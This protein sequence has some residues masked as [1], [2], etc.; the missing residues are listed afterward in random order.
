MSTWVCMSFIDDMIGDAE[1]SNIA[2]WVGVLLSDHLVQRSRSS[3]SISSTTT[4][5][6]P[7]NYVYQ[8]LLLD[9]SKT[10]SLRAPNIFL[11][12]RSVSLTSSFVLSKYSSTTS[13]PPFGLASPQLMRRTRNKLTCHESSGTRW[14]YSIPHKLSHL[15][16]YAIKD[17]WSAFS[18]NCSTMS[19]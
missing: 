13:L 16:V 2:W 11:N 9:G 17:V 1:C 19:T 14:L 10:S 5:T 18:R 4:I 3:N 7:F 8:A 6:I 15:E 12:K